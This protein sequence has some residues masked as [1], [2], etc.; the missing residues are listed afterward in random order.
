MYKVNWKTLVLIIITIFILNNLADAQKSSEPIITKKVG[1]S[2]TRDKQ[3][4]EAIRKW[5][6]ADGTDEIRYHFNKVDLNGDGNLDAVVSVLQQSSCGTGGCPML[7]FKSAGKDYELVTEMSVSRPPII[8]LPTK[9]KG[10][11][12]LVMFVSGGGIK[13]YYSLLKFDGRSYPENP[14]VAPKLP[15]GSKIKGVEYLSGIET[16]DTGFL[17]K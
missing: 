6:G 5:N 14:T 8:V 13:P 10:W 1:Y 16:Y 2:K 3:L 7:V 15:K 17:L 11:N 9:T 12:D 4:D